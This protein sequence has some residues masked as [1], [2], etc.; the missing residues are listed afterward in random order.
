M[1]Y[2]ETD[3]YVATID[4]VLKESRVTKAANLIKLFARASTSKRNYCELALSPPYTSPLSRYQAMCRGSREHAKAGVST[5][6]KRETVTPSSVHGTEFATRCFSDTTRY[7]NKNARIEK[8][9]HFDPGVSN[10]SFSFRS[11]SERGA[12]GRSILALSL[13]NNNETLELRWR[14]AYKLYC[15]RFAI[16][17]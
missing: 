3:N 14:E 16:E 7:G 15:A 17:D 6:Q 9:L 12:Q 8:K 10:V 13:C 11:R 5:L 2:Y 1:T 4:K